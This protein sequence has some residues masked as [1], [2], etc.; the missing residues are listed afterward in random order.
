[1]GKMVYLR[2]NNTIPQHDELKETP[3]E[4][5]EDHLPG[6]LHGFYPDSRPR[7]PATQNIYRLSLLRTPEQ[8]G[9]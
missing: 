9:I 3:I 4:E 1:M 8:F 6:T 5:P 2:M 7:A